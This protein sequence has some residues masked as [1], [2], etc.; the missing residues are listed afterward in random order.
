MAYWVPRG[1]RAEGA[2][3]FRNTTRVVEFYSRRFDYTYP[4]VKYD[5]IVVA[6]YPVGALEHTGVTGH[7]ESVLR[8]EGGTPDDF[9]APSFDEYH[10]D[11]T[12]EG[13]GLFRLPVTLT[14][15]TDEKTWD[16]LIWVESERLR[17]GISCPRDSCR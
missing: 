17:I 16:E 14:I 9:S 4:W 1:C 13:Q 2:W 11:W 7:H 6:D 3:T 15:A 8:L 10:P 5:P 12:A